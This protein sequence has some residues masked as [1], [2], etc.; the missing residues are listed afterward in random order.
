M[1]NTYDQHQ[2]YGRRSQPVSALMTADGWLSTGISFDDYGRMSVQQRK[3]SGE[4]RLATPI[5]AMNNALLR[6]VLIAF[7]EERAGFRKK[8]RTQTFT[9]FEK[10]ITKIDWYLQD[11]KRGGLIGE[12]V[13]AYYAARLDR[14]K[15]IIMGRR[16]G[17][18][19]V[20]DK[21]CAEYVEIKQKGLN[22]DITDKEWNESRPQPFMSFAEGEARYQDESLRLRQLEIEIEGI[23]TYLRITEN[24]GA[25]V[26][27]AVVY[28]YYRVGLDSVG[29]GIELGLK[30]PHVRQ[31][32]WKLHRTYDRMVAAGEVEVKK[33]QRV[34]HCKAKP[35]VKKKGLYTPPLLA[36]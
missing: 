36:V 27:C 22:P 8:K 28:L 11:T 19:A 33:V 15:S 2:F 17:M 7:M 25:D 23:D 18:I 5:W 1:K 24:G 16:S 31:T 9:R 10:K 30:P 12:V 32:L 29:V 13:H 6:R 3:Q 21:L 26:I 35:T 14:A 34:M 20:M 4:R